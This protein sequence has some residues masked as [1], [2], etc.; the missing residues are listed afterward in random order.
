[1]TIENQILL[2]KLTET[3]D[4]KL[5]PLSS[6]AFSP[7]QLSA[8]PVSFSG[9][10]PMRRTSPGNGEN[11]LEYSQNGNAK[12]DRGEPGKVGNRTI[13][14]DKDTNVFDWVIDQKSADE[15]AAE[16]TKQLVDEGR[17]KS[18]RAIHPRTIQRFLARE[19]IQE[20]FR[21]YRIGWIRSIAASLVGDVKDVIGEE[22]F[23]NYAP[24]PSKNTFLQQNSVLVE[25][26]QQAI[27]D[28]T[29][30]ARE[31]IMIK[32]GT[33]FALITI[34][35]FGETKPPPLQDRKE[36]ALR[37]F[38]IAGDLAITLAISL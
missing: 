25:A 37:A 6:T 22:N 12:I 20:K 7:D 27:G 26:S 30:G 10:Y 36:R 23:L 31:K 19:D 9:V 1:M 13:P 21:V 17:R 29:W 18:K 38:L 8:G 24:A 16:L 28:F 14:T 5:L 4:A 33:P 15:I 35:P 34:L 11:G 3:V 32:H 2:T